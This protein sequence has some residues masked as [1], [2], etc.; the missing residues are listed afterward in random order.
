MISLYWGNPGCGK[1]TLA[2]KMIAADI[3]GRKHAHVY[4]NFHTTLCPYMSVE[5]LG[6][7]TPPPGSLLVIDEAG[8]EYNSRLYKTLH[9]SVIKWYKLHRHY[10]VDVIVISQSWEDID[11]TVRRLYDRLYHLA[12]LP[13]VTVVRR[14]Y[15][16]TGID[17]QTHQICDMYRFGKLLPCLWGADNVRF[18]LRL[19]WYRYM[20]S[21]AAPPLPVKQ[22]S[23]RPPLFRGL[24]ALRA[25]MR[26]HKPLPFSCW[27]FRKCDR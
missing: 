25:R 19:R 11:V 22:P 6:T 10:G 2:C 23:D 4:A 5:G 15:R 17:E 14:V 8:I 24:T 18:C 16:W 12:R 27:P 7:W 1:T 13:L 9:Q 26:Q 21:W 20:D 3:I